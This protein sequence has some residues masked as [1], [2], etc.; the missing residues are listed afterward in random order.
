MQ[1]SFLGY[2][3][4][5]KKASLPSMDCPAH[6]QSLLVGCPQLCRYPKLIQAEGKDSKQDE[7]LQWQQRRC[8]TGVRNIGLG[9]RRVWSYI[10]QL[11]SR[12]GY[13]ISTRDL[14]QGRAYP[15]S[16]PE[17]S[18]CLSCLALA[19]VA[20]PPYFS[21]NPFELLRHDSYHI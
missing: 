4:I 19:K 15:R 14:E 17:A 16:P 21:R 18:F 7:P 10:L 12:L 9:G 6:A 13:D 1:G 3:A 5:L 8:I 11:A 20:P 2:Q